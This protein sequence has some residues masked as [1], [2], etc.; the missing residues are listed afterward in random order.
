MTNLDGSSFNVLSIDVTDI[1]NQDWASY[2]DPIYGGFYYPTQPG[3]ISLWADLESGGTLSTTFQV[4][5]VQGWQTINLNWTGV[6]AFYFRNDGSNSNSSFQADNI[7][8]NVVPIPAAVWMFGSAI[9]ALG[10]Y[11]RKKVAL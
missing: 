7:V 11:R 4:D 8:V 5:E 2:S 10:L 9:A 1:F 6:T 3:T